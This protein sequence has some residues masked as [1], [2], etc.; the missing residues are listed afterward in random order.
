MT[1]NLNKMIVKT[2]ALPCFVASSAAGLDAQDRCQALDGFA[3]RTGDK[4]R[5]GAD[6]IDPRARALIAPVQR[7]S[8]NGLPRN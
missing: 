5:F 2:R 6:Y 3:P 7:F 4:T 8:L 1:W